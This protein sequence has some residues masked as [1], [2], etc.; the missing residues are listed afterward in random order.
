MV[1]TY[2]SFSSKYGECINLEI[3]MWLLVK[4]EAAAHTIEREIEKIF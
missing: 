1:Q 4:K 3:T 2:P